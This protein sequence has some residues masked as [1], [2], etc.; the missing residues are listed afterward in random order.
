MRRLVV[1]GVLIT[2]FVAT[3]AAAPAAA[4]GCGV[5]APAG[6]A[7]TVLDERA[8]ISWDGERQTIELALDLDS[9]SLSAGLLIPTPQP[10]SVTV[11]DARTFALIEDLIEPEMVE[12][13]DWW[14]LGYLSAAPGPNDSSP[15]QRVDPG[16]LEMTSLDASDTAGLQTWLGTNSFELTE[17]MTET[18]EVYA[19]LGWSFTGI[20]LANEDGF[21]GRLDPIRLTFD[22]SSM[23]YPLR[24]ASSASGPQTLR[25]YVFD[26]H[27]D[28][29]VRASQ[30]TMNLEGDVDVLWA[31]KAEDARLAVLGEYLTAIDLRFDNPEEQVTSDIGFVRSIDSA[32]LKPTVV[33]YHM[34]TLLG[35]PV[36][37][38]VVAWLVLGFSL[39]LG[40]VVGR[41]RAR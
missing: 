11:G 21:D 1:T 40:H 2:F 32:D 37:T 38:L 14:G 15:P 18:L 10:A 13:T 9:S 25:L 31:G 20:R 19:E 7:A 24:L 17:T 3:G 8:I 16:A 34:V 41:R 27:R 29:V 33:E 26:A 22:T 35:I 6:S 23:V 30:P 28:S 5:L 4:C 36:G 39:G 12:Q